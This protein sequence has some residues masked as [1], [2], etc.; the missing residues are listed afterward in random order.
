MD[1][2]CA[3]AVG[4]DTLCDEHKVVLKDHLEEAICEV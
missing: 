4:F 1:A 3:Q 2:A